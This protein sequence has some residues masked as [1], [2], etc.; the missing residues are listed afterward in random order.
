MDNVL[1]NKDYESES[2]G[3][4]FSVKGILAELFDEHTDG[5]LYLVEW[6][7]YPMHEYVHR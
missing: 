2:D 3:Q 4:I 5:P 7:G 6:E 1:D